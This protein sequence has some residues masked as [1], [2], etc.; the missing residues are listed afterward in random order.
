MTGIS[1]TAKVFLCVAASG[2]DGCTAGRVS[3]ELGL[4]M[5][6]AR[7]ILVAG[8][9]EGALSSQVMSNGERDLCTVY[10]SRRF[11]V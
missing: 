4:D 3:R 2:R 6:E 11:S 1:T 8:C 5:D 10:R 7:R 9:L